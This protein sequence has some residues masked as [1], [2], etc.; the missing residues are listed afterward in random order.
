MEQRSI[1]L[2]AVHT[3]CGCSSE[4]LPTLAEDNMD[5]TDR[6]IVEELQHNCRIS[7]ETLSRNIGITGN[8]VKRRIRK[9]TEEGVIADY[10]IC[11]SFAM[12]DAEPMLTL[13]ELDGT[14]DDDILIDTIGAHPF[15]NRVGFDSHGWLVVWVEYVGT[16]GLLEISSFLRG[17]KGVRDIELNPLP[18]N[19]R[20]GKT[21]FSRNQLKLLK[22]LLDDPRMALSKMA[23]KA[24][25]TVKRA[26]K[27]LSEIQESDA[28]WFTA[29][30]NTNAGTTTRFVLRIS[31]DEKKTNANEIIE[32]A[33]TKYPE[34]YAGTHIS[35]SA[36]RMFLLF[37]VEHIREAEYISREVTTIPSVVHHST[38]IP[39]PAKLF[40]GIRET[41]LVEII[42]NSGV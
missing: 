35:A 9:L 41:K 28:V 33:K 22:V 1:S 18:N 31:W 42:E 20:G 8:S 2:T 5:K 29:Q 21:E 36:P 23:K 12:C 40:K 10:I 13:V 11:L 34:E 3:D 26:R 37:T 30:I 17:L 25:M 7:Y 4:N 6:R 39:Y 19:R 24:K 27:T 15:V 16:D 38:I 14:Q 32:W